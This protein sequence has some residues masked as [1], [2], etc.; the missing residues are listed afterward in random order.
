MWWA[1]GLAG[2]FVFGVNNWIF[3]LWNTGQTAAGRLKATAEFVAALLTGAIFAQAWTGSAHRFIGQWFA[4]DMIAVALT[5]GWASNY[6]WPRI[7]RRL[8]EQVDKLDLKG[9][10]I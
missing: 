5:I 9:P 2:A 7:L 6:L 1:W 3:A 8:G 4:A 10:G